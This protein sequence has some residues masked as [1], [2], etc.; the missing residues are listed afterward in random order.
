M[1]LDARASSQGVRR[2]RCFFLPLFPVLNAT[3]LRRRTRQ[4]SQERADILLHWAAG[5]VD[6]VTAVNQEEGRL[7]SDMLKSH[8]MVDIINLLRNI[9]S[10]R[11]KMYIKAKFHLSL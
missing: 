9:F 4:D 10:G 3:Y 1:L 11:P 7:G 8:I 6:W 5:S 2:S